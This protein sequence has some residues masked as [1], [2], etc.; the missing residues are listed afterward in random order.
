MEYRV[1]G[2]FLHIFWFK[3]KNLEERGVCSRS[4]SDLQYTTVEK[5]VDRKGSV[6]FSLDSW[7]PF[8]GLFLSHD[9]TMPRKKQ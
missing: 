2:T 8:Q 6:P 1:Q 5:S 9:Q 4:G 3:R 7:D